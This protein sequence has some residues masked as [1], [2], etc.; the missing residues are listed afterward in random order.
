M[1]VSVFNELDDFMLEATFKKFDK[2]GSQF[3]NA[4]TSGGLD[5]EDLKRI[6]GAEFDGTDVEA[7]VSEGDLNGDG[8]LDFQEFAQ[9]VRSRDSGTWNQA[10]F[11]VVEVPRSGRRSGDASCGGC[12]GVAPVLLG[13]E[14]PSGGGAHKVAERGCGPAVVEVTATQP[15]A[16]CIVM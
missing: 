6:L 1:C 3:V 16:C 10:E 14:H 9:F 12:N 8:K 11:G 4:K 5:A 15:H 7:L 13:R 2:T